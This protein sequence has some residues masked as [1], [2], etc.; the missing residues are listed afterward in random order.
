M[1]TLKKI[2]QVFEIL[3]LYEHTWNKYT[4]ILTQLSF[5]LSGTK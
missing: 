4:P 3:E 5:E 1:I 2:R